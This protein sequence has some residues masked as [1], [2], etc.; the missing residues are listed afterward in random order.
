MREKS[1]A[2]RHGFIL[3]DA[4]WRLLEKACEPGT[5]P[6]GRLLSMCESLPFPLRTGGVCWGHD[7]GQ[8]LALDTESCYPWHE[9]FHPPA[10]SSLALSWALENPFEIPELR[11]ISSN[12]ALPPTAND[13]V[14]PGRDCFD[15]LP[16]EIREMIA[17][18][19]P[20]IDALSLR[21]ACKSFLHIYGSAK[22]WFS[23]FQMDSER[24][25]LFEFRG[26]KNIVKLRSLY[27]ATI[28][29]RRSSALRN[30][31]RIWCLGRQLIRIARHS[32][33]DHTA[34]GKL[35]AMAPQDWVRLS[36][37]DHNEEL[38]PS[39]EPF[40]RGCRSVDTVTLAV[41]A[42][43]SQIGITTISLGALDYIT[44]IRLLADE[45][46][47]ARAGY[48]SHSDEILCPL[49]G[50]RGFR[51][52]VG[53]GGVRALQAIDRDGCSLPWIGRVEGLPVSER[54]IG[55]EPLK[56]LRVTTDV[57]KTY[58]PRIFIAH[59]VWLGL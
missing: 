21:L 3:H 55:L 56:S 17:A 46:S 48:Q 10:E 2:G 27:R 14:T 35:S 28:P 25:F 26:C 31:Q 18:L 57:R 13:A 9:Q 50:L 49:H 53:P 7:Y 38:T 30:R 24:G 43:L 4:C 6:L 58:S 54:L 8:L 45:E 16:W 1:S 5:V 29:S 33:E 36:G 11:E 59:S 40:E 23:R 15:K 37:D 39:W 42:R 12:L 19:L 44:G 22:F 20:T 52:A 41:P 47:N 51:L 34:D 32:H